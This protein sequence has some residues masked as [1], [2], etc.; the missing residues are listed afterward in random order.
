MAAKQ[1]AESLRNGRPDHGEMGGRMSANSAIKTSFWKLNPRLNPEIYDARAAPPPPF[2]AR[3][4]PEQRNETELQ[5]CVDHV[6]SPARLR[7]HNR[8]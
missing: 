8:P 3:K 4:V 5:M 6:Q 7:L 2:P 1:V